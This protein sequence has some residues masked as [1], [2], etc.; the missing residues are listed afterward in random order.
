MP[1]ETREEAATRTKRNKA[2]VSFT[3]FLPNS[4]KKSAKYT[5]HS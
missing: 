2:H 3:D 5:M 1:K 4:I